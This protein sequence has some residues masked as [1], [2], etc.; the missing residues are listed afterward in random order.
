MCIKRFFF[1]FKETRH[2]FT[3]NTFYFLTFDELHC[4]KNIVILTIE[5]Q[6]GFLKQLL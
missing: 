5:T 4:W 1:F 6:M 3:M 2:F